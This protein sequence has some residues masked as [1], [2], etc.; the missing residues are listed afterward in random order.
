MKRSTPPAP[1]RAKGRAPLP[2]TQLA[3]VLREAAEHRLARRDDQAIALYAHVERH[4]PE[5]L[6]APYF[7]ALI[8]L[9]RV[10]PADALPRLE[11]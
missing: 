1:N 11:A 2:P 5:A 9:A 6:D 8:D 3:L 10:R 7:L 4:N